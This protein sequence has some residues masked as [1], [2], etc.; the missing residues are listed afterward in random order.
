MFSY[1]LLQLGKPESKEEKKEEEEEAAA[2]RHPSVSAL[3]KPPRWN[4]CATNGVME[5]K[6]G[7]DFYYATDCREVYIFAGGEVKTSW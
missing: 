3:L 7:V 2:A 6:K 4:T 5:K 1:T